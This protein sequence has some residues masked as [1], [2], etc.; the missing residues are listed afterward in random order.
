MGLGASCRHSRLACPCLVIRAGARQRAWA[1]TDTSSHAGCEHL[2][3]DHGV[4]VDF[5]TADPLIRWDSY[6]SLSAGGEGTSGRRRLGLGGLG[7]AACSWSAWRPETLPSFGAQRPPTGAVSLGE[8]VRSRLG[9]FGWRIWHSRAG[10]APWSS[11]GRN[12]CLHVAKD[13]FPSSS[14][15]SRSCGGAPSVGSPGSLGR[16]CWSC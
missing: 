10:P 1:V 15:A 8:P 11:L 6:E 9:E 16:G 2:R 7:K 13:R 14:P 12:A 4:I 3:N 5:N